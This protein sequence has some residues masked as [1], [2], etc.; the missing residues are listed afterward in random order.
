MFGPKSSPRRFPSILS[1]LVV[2]VAHTAPT[3]VCDSAKDI[4]MSLVEMTTSFMKEG[5]PMAAGGD[6]R[7]INAGL[8]DCILDIQASEGRANRDRGG[9]FGVHLS[10]G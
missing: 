3:K 8:M 10:G 6:P 2:V 5:S 4:I 9:P 7:N 1:S